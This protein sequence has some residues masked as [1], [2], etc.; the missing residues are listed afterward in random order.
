MIKQYLEDVFNTSDNYYL[1]ILRYFNPIGAYKSR[2]IV[3]DP[4]DI[5]NNLIPFV[6]EVAIGKIK[7]L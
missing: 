6:S 3:K 4:N 1:G 7:K 2:L 5:P